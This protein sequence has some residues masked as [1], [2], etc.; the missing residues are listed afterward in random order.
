MSTNEMNAFKRVPPIAN[1]TIDGLIKKMSAGIDYAEIE[2]QG[3]QNMVRRIKII[4]EQGNNAKE[5]FAKK[6]G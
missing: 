6:F 4:E 1:E 2:K 5:H 3:A